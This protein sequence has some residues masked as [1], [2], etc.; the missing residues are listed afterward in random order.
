MTELQETLYTELVTKYV[1]TVCD[2][3]DER[4]CSPCR[5]KAFN[6]FAKDE[7]LKISAFVTYAEFEAYSTI[8]SEM[9]DII[10]KR[11]ENEEI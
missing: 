4:Q 3:D 5:N 2:C 7:I 8:Y 1:N 10:T 11:N 9:S 6:K